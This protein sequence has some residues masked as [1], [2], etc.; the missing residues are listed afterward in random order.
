MRFRMVRRKAL[1]LLGVSLVIG[2]LL[3]STR[4]LFL[5][6]PETTDPISFR[7]SHVSQ[8]EEM[9]KLNFASPS[10]LAD[11]V[12]NADYQQFVLNADRFPEEPQLVLVV[13]VH[14]RSDYLRLLVRSLESAAEVQGF[15]VIFSHDYFSEEINSIVQGITFCKVIQIY[16]PYSTQLYPNSFPG[17]DPKDCPRDAARD[18]AVRSGCLNA[19]HPDSYGHYR[20]AAITQTKHHW[21]WKMHFV[22]ERVGAVQG[23]HGFAVFLEEDHYL[24]PDFYHHYRAMAAYRAASC[25][26]CDVLALGNHKVPDGGFGGHSDRLQTAS[27]ESTKHNMGLA[28]SREV[29]Y[30]LM[31][32]NEA[33]CTYDDYNWD[34]TLQHLSGTCIAKPL[35][36]LAALG[37]RVLHTGDCGLHQ[38]KEEC[39]PE[40]AAR[41]VEEVLQRVKGSLF[42]ASLSLSG[43][44][45]VEHRPHVKNGGWGD[46]RD[47][48]LCKNYA[49][50]L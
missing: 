10:E 22:W 46:L 24:L 15:L 5:S 1:A 3:F 47:H 4:V 9:V 40:L 42:P 26:D 38:K 17:H 12:L 19:E 37:S 29:Y 25:P 21:W 13:Q 11:S 39:R 27:W 50:R 30:K 16:F 6:D 43:G 23:Y 18:Q 48:V 35:K 49:R 8:S 20:E 32:C 36:V 44:E 45:K 31:G 33:F 41:R 7:D 34:W 28:L 14:N 2:T